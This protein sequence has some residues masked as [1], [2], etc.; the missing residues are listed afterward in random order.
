MEEKNFSLRPVGSMRKPMSPALIWGNKFRITI[1]NLEEAE[2]VLSNLE[3]VKIYGFPNFFDDQRFRGIDFSLGFFA[4]RVLRGY[5]N[6]ALQIFLQSQNI[7]SSDKKGRERVAEIISNWRNWEKCLELAKGLTEKRIFRSLVHR[8]DDFLAALEKI[9]REEISMAYA[10]FGS[11]LWNELLRKLLREKVPE[12]REFQAE[13]GI[14]YFWKSL[15]E[16]VFD[17][18]K[19]LKLPTPAAKMQFPDEL[20]RDLYLKVLEENN[21]KFSSFRTRALSRVFFR[22]FQRKVLLYPEDLEI[23]EVREDQL[24]PGKKALVLAFT[25]P[26]GAFATMLIKRILFERG[27]P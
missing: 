5:Y 18:L 7:R 21:L 14:F 12:L 8:P 25:L 15:K 11:H 2:S 26:R 19:N 10:A 6:G 16:P 1:R 9:P 17:Y 24:H 3:E 22:S 13:S 23:V 27:K 4:D 20:T